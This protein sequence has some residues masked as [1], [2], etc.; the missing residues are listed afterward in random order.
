MWWIFESGLFGIIFV[1]IFAIVICGFI[2]VIVTGLRQWNKNNHS[3]RLTVDAQ[4]VA[5]RINVTHHS[6]THH[7]GI[8]HNDTHHSMGHTST[9]HYITFQVESGDRMEFH[10]T[11]QEYGLLVE[12]DR[13][14]LT[15]QGTRYLGFERQR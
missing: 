5:K 4:V 3:P 11:G 8:H 1:L 2:Y 9:S 10:V 12:G 15:F 13:G 6:D 14:R 7:S